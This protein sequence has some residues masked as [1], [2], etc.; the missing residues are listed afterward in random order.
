[1]GTI[2]REWLNENTHRQFPLAD[3]AP[4]K[5]TTGGF[6]L[7]QSFLTDMFLCAPLTAD[8]TK[9]FVSNIVVRTYTIDVTISYEKGVGDDIVVGTFR[10]LDTTSDSYTIFPF[11]PATQPL[12]A[13]KPMELMKGSVVIGVMEEIK[14]HAGS[15]N[16]DLTNGAIQPTCVSQGLAAL[17]SIQVGSQIF[18]G[19]IKLKEG[20]NIRLIPSYNPMTGITV[21]TISA[22]LGGVDTLTVPLTNDTAVFQNLVNTYGTPMTTINGVRPDSNGNFVL[23]PMDCT[24]FKPVTGGLEIRNPCSLPCC[25]KSVLDDIYESVSQ[26]NQR[27]ARMQSYYE[28]LSR[29]VNEL[30]AQLLGLEL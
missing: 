3:T 30:Q 29:N 18:T 17:H 16:F 1:M 8:I 7:P 23:Q 22:D 28:N 13:D 25:D 4:G 26:L 5:D 2:L 21:I 12:D 14:Q 6:E 15:W 27:Y 11:S 10:E 24:E 20:V 9:F 19:D